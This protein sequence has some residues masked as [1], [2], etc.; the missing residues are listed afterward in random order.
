MVAKLR[1]YLPDWK[2]YF[3]LAE[4]PKTFAEY[5]KWVRHRLRTLQLKRRKRGSKV[6]AEM[7][8]LGLLEPDTAL[9][10]RVNKG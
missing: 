2:E 7:G 8:R 10:A 6:Y 4:T 1:Q 9:A 5:D 3:R